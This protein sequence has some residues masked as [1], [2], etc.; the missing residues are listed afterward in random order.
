MKKRKKI[1][2]LSREHK[3]A[4]SKLQTR[5][6]FKG[7]LSFLKVQQNNIGVFQWTRVKS[8]DPDIALKKARYEG[9]FEIIN[10]LI[11]AFEEARKGEE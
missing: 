4:L 10:L 1:I 5:P 6:E 2:Y 9:Q 8:N 11:K 3:E 7:F